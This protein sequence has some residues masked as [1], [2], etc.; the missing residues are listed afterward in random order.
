MVKVYI[1]NPSHIGSIKATPQAQY[2]YNEWEKKLESSREDSKWLAELNRYKPNSFWEVDITGPRKFPNRGLLSRSVGHASLHLLNSTHD[3]YFSVYPDTQ[4]K[5]I[6]LIVNFKSRYPSKFAIDIDADMEEIQG[7][8]DHVIHLDN[9]DESAI[10]AQ[11]SYVNTHYTKYIL[12]GRNCSN[13]VMDLLNVGS[14]QQESSLL[15]GLKNIYH[16]AKTVASAF[17]FMSAIQSEQ[18]RSFPLQFGFEP[19]RSMVAFHQMC[20][21][22]TPEAVYNHAKFLKKKVG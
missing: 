10:A 22:Y 15:S 18:Y 6:N 12:C 17:V 1:W 7:R 5:D 9:L 16:G 8:P 21:G 13:L 3:V 20:G 2:V 19:M 11:M 14:K 4:G